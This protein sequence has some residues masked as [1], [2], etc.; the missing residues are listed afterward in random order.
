MMIKSTWVDLSC[1]SWFTGRACERLC[2]CIW[3]IFTLFNRGNPSSLWLV[4]LFA[5]ICLNWWVDDCSDG[6][7]KIES[8]DI[9]DPNKAI[10]GSPSSSFW[11]FMR[12]ERI[13]VSSSSVM[14]KRWVRVLVDWSQLVL[15]EGRRYC[16][17]DRVQVCWSPSG[18]ITMA[19]ICA[20]WSSCAILERHSMASLRRRDHSR[21]CMYI[22]W[23][24]RCVSLYDD[25]VI[26]SAI[27]NVHP[28]GCKWNARFILNRSISRSFLLF[29]WAC[30]GCAFSSIVTIKVNFLGKWASGQSQGE[31]RGKSITRQQPKY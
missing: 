5:S 15:V 17:A 16:W 25:C 8:E 13:S 7:L 23:G 26:K 18:A 29:M 11:R 6:G 12:D 22:T 27:L 21:R 24:Y 20:L 31:S 30:F 2:I 3:S 9:K 19:L 28:G 1:G 4:S 14:F 10:V